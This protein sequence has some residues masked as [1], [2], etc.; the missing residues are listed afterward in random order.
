MFTSNNATGGS[1]PESHLSPRGIQGDRCPR[2]DLLRAA[3]VRRCSNIDETAHDNFAIRDKGDID[4]EMHCGDDYFFGIS[5]A[6]SSTTL[7]VPER[8]G[9]ISYWIRGYR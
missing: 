2:E 6:S 5:N 8:I 4:G 9:F 3:G 7:S 1:G